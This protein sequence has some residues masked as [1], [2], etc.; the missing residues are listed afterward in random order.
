MKPD[1]AQQI[2]PDYT[3]HTMSVYA[4][5]TKLFIQSSG[6]LDPIREGNPWG[7]TRTPSWVADWEW[8]GRARMSRTECQLWG[9]SWLYSKSK[10]MIDVP[11]QASGT[12]TSDVSFSSDGLLLTCTGFVIDS[13]SGLSAR[14]EEYFA[15][16]KTSISQ[17]EQWKS[18]YG[19]KKATSEALYRTIVADRVSGGNKADNRHSAIFHLPST[20]AKAKTQFAKLGWSWLSAQEDYYFR[21]QKWRAANRDFLL[22]DH[23]LSIF[24]MTRFPKGHLNS[25]LPKYTPALIAHVRSDDS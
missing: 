22:G 11:Y 3:I 4:N 10:P 2:I 13:I 24:S 17:P 14:G 6:N 16:S 9:P 12:R 23:K 19:D 5:A 1:I 15:W 21:W 25:T 7:P 18:I 20:F 8:E